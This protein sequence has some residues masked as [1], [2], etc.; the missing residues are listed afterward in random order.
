[1][2]LSSDMKDEDLTIMAVI[3]YAMH[4]ATAHYR[5]SVAPVETSVQDALEQWSKIAVEGHG[6]SAFV[7]AHARRGRY[8]RGTS[9]QL[10]QQ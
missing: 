2:R 4:R 9:A 7:L 1:M 3:N 10:Q 6:P 8:L 5:G